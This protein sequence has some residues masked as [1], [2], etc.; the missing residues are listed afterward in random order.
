MDLCLWPI[1]PYHGQAPLTQSQI[2]RIYEA[3]V[4]EV[5]PEEEP[6]YFVHYKGWKGT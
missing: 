2:N 5:E 3:K 4:I 6:H 1:F